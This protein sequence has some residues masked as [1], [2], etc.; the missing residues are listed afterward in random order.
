[1]SAKDPY[2]RPLF[3]ARNEQVEVGNLGT[4]EEVLDEPVPREVVVKPKVRRRNWF[5]RAGAFAGYHIRFIVL[6]LLINLFL[7]IIVNW[8]QSPLET[9]VWLRD[10]VNAYVKTLMS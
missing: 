4:T 1:M 8:H 3:Y 6:L 7:L 9:F 10:V 5:W 2:L